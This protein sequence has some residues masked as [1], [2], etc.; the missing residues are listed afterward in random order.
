[1]LINKDKG[2]TSK[3][4][5]YKPLCVLDTRKLLERFVKNR[6]LTDV[7]RIGELSFRQHE[8]RRATRLLVPYRKQLIPTKI[9]Q[10]KNRHTREI[11]TAVTLDVK[12]AFNS[13]R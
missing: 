10:R 8:F 4:S 9:E 5:A 7:E 11:V 13:A 12:N 1:M 6:L 3:T 2:D